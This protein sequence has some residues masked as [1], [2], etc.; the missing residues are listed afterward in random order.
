MKNAAQRQIQRDPLRVAQDVGPSEETRLDALLGRMRALEAK[1]EELERQNKFLGTSFEHD[2]S[3]HPSRLDQLTAACAENGFP[4]SADGY[5]RESH[6]ARLIN[7]ASVTLRN[8]RYCE[9]PLPYR[10]FAGRIEYRLADL[11]AFMEGR[12]E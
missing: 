5:I 6:A 11:A 12:E 2:K 7:R 10:L 8:W 9:R 4:L 3:C 1:V